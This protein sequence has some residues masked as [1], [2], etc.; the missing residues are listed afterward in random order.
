V[1]AALPN[2]PEDE[3]ALKAMAATLLGERDQER[4][5][6]E[7]QA[8][9]A[10]DLHIE[11]LRLQVELARYKKQCYGPRADQLHSEG[12]LAQLL[13]TFAEALDGKPV[14]REDVPAHSQPQE[15]LP[16]VKRREG[17]RNLSN[18]ENLPV[19]THIYELN[20]EQRACPCC[21]VERKEIGS[22]ESWQIEYYRGHFERLHHARKNYAWPACEHNG[23]NPQ[24][25]TAAKPQ[26]GIEKGLAAPGLLSYI[27]TS[28]FAEY[29]PLYR[30]EDI[31]ARQGFEIPRATQSVWCGDVADL[32]DR[33]RASN[34]TFRGGLAV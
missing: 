33:T 5:R 29:L 26:T 30:L 27:V 28:K 16:H 15:E 31:F 8:R 3:E 17:R 19:T 24:M 2:L 4:Q 10:N 32:V 13:L 7:E 18:F 14:N 22:D 20:A 12:E 25:A 34:H 1:P 11:I 23:K 6:A 9:R 21:G